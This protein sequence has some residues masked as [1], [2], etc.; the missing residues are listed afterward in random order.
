M[1]TQTHNLEEGPLSLN[2]VFASFVA[3]EVIA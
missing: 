3:D 1:S 2:K